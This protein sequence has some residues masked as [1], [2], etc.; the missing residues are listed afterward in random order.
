MIVYH[1]TTLEISSPKILSTE[2]GRDFRARFTRQI[3]YQ[4]KQNARLSDELKSFPK[5]KTKMF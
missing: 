2:I 4:S 5:G 3:I 1:G